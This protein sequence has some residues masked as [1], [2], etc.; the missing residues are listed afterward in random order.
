MKKIKYVLGGLLT[1]AVLFSSCS[2]DNFTDYHNDI[3]GK[4][5][6]PAMFSDQTNYIADLYLAY[7]GNYNRMEYTPEQLAPYVY[8]DNGKTNW[9][10]DG[11]LF[12]ALDLPSGRKAGI[13]ANK[14]DWKWI[15]KRHLGTEECVGVSALNTLL[16]DLKNEGKQPVRKRKVVISIPAPVTQSF[17]WGELDGVEL[18]MTKN[19]DRIKAIKWFIDE[20]LAAWKETSYTEVELAGLYWLHEGESTH[21]DDE[22]ILPTVADYVHSKGLHFYWIP[23]Y[24]AR[25]GAFKWKECGFDIAYQQPNYFFIKEPESPASRLNDACRYAS[26][27]RMGLEFECNHKVFT[28]TVYQRRFHEYVDYFIENRVIELAPI[29][30]YDNRGALYDMYQSEEPELRALYDRL[31]LLIIDRQKRADELYLN[32]KVK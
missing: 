7:Q 23:Y 6:Y 18:D 17:V 10:Y 3:Q 1:A 32:S 4:Y 30:Y 25:M 9:L 8:W 19:S 2:K 29:A 27:Y 11:F 24:G 5:D 22:L 16:V 14:E 20:L 15:I 12:L 31:S 28:D 21:V 13:D 26:K